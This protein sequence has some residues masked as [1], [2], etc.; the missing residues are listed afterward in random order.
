MVGAPK[1][2]FEAGFFSSFVFVAVVGAPKLNGVGVALLLPIV[3]ETSLEPAKPR[4]LCGSSSPL[5]SSNPLFF[6]A[7]SPPL[8][9]PKD[10]EG[11]PKE[12]AGVGFV[13]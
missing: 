1:E 9:I 6:A 10:V 4:F 11:A 7:S 3:L 5:L 2:K 12:N 8:V 13:C